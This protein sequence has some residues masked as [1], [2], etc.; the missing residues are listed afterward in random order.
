MSRLSVRVVV[1]VSALLVIL[2]SCGSGGSTSTSASST[3]ETS[4]A[5]SASPAAQPETAVWPFAASSPGFTDPVAA[6]R[7]F[8]V[9]YVGFVDP[10]V[11]A[12]QGGDSQSGEVPVQAR[13]G[14]SVT[15]VF[16][17]KLTSA[18]TWWVLGASNPSI[19]IT[20]PAALAAISSP[21]MLSGQSTAFEATVNVE[22]RQDDTLVPL[23]EDFVMGGSMGDLGPFSKAVSFNVPSAAGGAVVLETR[24]P[25]DGN[26]SE[27][28]VVRVA[29]A[30]VAPRATG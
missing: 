26:V 12:F 13:A 23:G 18:Q 29:F 25:E 27:A 1:G 28:S 20:S 30:G 8:A 15:T 11:G 9:D 24:S 22:I 16:V 17:R 10:L 21:V 19:Q 6:A 5:Q 2:A 7:S 14:G 4:T 3:P